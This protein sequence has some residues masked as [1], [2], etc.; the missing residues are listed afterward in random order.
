[1]PDVFE[2]RW[3]CNICC[4]NTIQCFS[5]GSWGHFEESTWCG[6]P[7]QCCGCLLRVVVPLGSYRLPIFFCLTNPRL[8]LSISLCLHDSCTVALVCTYA[9]AECTAV[10]CLAQ[11]CMLFVQL[12][13][14]FCLFVAPCHISSCFVY[15]TFR[16]LHLSILCHCVISARDSQR[17]SGARGSL[18]QVC[19]LYRSTCSTSSIY[20]ARVRVRS[21]LP[22]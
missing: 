9:C 4:V 12:S 8:Q 17:F 22:L 3:L 1:M 19:S 18:N 2:T 15:C 14:S 7:A 21:S 5:C 6:G 13:W 11:I 16:F 20:S 10:L